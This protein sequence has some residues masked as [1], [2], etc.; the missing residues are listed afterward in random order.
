MNR[1][2]AVASAMG[3]LGIPSC[4]FSCHFLLFCAASGDVYA[5]AALPLIA[6]MFA[7]LFIMG[8]KAVK[9]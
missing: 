9:Y 8:R 4:M 3:M 6:L 5:A 1:V 2:D 7:L